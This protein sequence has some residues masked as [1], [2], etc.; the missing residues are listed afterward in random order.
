[1]VRNIKD[2]LDDYEPYMTL[3]NDYSIKESPYKNKINYSDFL[4]GRTGLYWGE[5]WIRGCGANFILDF[6]C[7]PEKYDS[8]INSEN[9]SYEN[10]YSL[11]RD[12]TEEEKEETGKFAY[13]V[14]INNLEAINILSHL[15]K[16]LC[17]NDSNYIEPYRILRIQMERIFKLANIFSFD[18][19][20]DSE[21]EKIELT[22]TEYK[23]QLL[24]KMS[25][26][27]ITAFA[28]DNIDNLTQIKK[29]LIPLYKYDAP[30]LLQQFEES[31]NEIANKLITTSNENKQTKILEADIDKVFNSNKG[32]SIVRDEIISTL[33]TAEFL[34][35]KYILEQAPD[36][37]WD[38]SF[39]SILYY[40]VLEK[41]LNILIYK[42]YIQEIGNGPFSEKDIQNYFG[43]AR[44][45]D[46]KKNNF[47]AKDSLELGVC[48]FLLSEA[49]YSNNFSR[50]LR[51]KY[52]N[53][54]LINIEKIADTLKNTISIRRNDAA[55]PKLIEYKV[56]KEDKLYIYSGNSYK[57]SIEL[58]DMFEF[59]LVSLLN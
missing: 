54:N 22:A 43:K 55:H 52:P 8:L 30:W 41:S 11:T 51:K 28:N 29:D 59:L 57:E 42:P 26:K 49:K 20:D 33:T 46:K 1:M 35:K 56:A 31:I 39:I 21:V 2:Y 37:N 34:Y 32:Y 5:S 13:I 24:L 40:Q 19:Y 10:Y 53:Y 15:L 7:N 58:H 50:F 18:Y 47:F 16:Y 25:S 6:E 48:G 9:L 23:H 44:C 36:V 4:A 12:L 45:S 17:E 3:L 14:I 27:L 38:Y